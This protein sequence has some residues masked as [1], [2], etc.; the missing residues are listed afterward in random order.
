MLYL[1]VAIMTTIMVMNIENSLMHSQELHWDM[2]AFMASVG[3]K[4]T[5]AVNTSQSVSVVRIHHWNSNVSLHTSLNSILGLLKLL[6]GLTTSGRCCW[7]SHPA[8]VVC[9]ASSLCSPHMDVQT[10]CPNIPKG[11][12]VALLPHIDLDT[13][14]FSLDWRR[15]NSFFSAWLVGYLSAHELLKGAALFIL[16]LMILWEG[17]RYRN[18]LLRVKMV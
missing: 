13:K 1:V 17:N 8:R 15:R 14:W 5:C 7:I 3:D 11:F 18:I 6:D 10:L 12:G 2:K 4:Y 9:T 16:E